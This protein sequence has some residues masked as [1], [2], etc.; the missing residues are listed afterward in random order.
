MKNLVLNIGLT[1]SLGFIQLS[2]NEV[3]LNFAHMGDLHGHLIP[4]D[5]VTPGDSHVKQGGL[6]YLYSAIEDIR[7]QDKETILI[8]TGDTVQGGAEVLYTR[9][10]AI[11]T[12]L[13]EF[14]IDYG[15]LGNW[16]HLYGEKR[17]AE[18]FFNKDKLAN[19]T[20]LVSNVYKRSTNE[21]L[22]APYKIFERKGVKI[23]IIGFTSERPAM[24]V[25]PSGFDEIRFTNGDEEYEKYV[26]LLRPQVDVLVVISE[27]GLAKNIQLAKKFPGVNV[28]FSSDM[29]EITTK[30]VALKN[31]TI[32]VEEGA[33]GTRLGHIQLFVKDGKVTG[34]TFKM[35]TIDVNIKPNA[36]IAALVE[37]VRAPFLNDKTAK[38]YKSQFSQKELRGN[39]I[40]TVGETEIDLHRSNFTDAPKMQA[41][42]ESSS[43]NFI[44]EAFRIESG[45][46]LGVVRGFRYGTHVAKGDIQR[47]DIFHYIPISPWI[48]I[49]EISAK[50]LL[51]YL[52]NVAYGSLAT[53][54]SLWKGGWNHTVSG[55]KY[56]LDPN[57]KKGHMVSNLRILQDGKYVAVDLNKTYTIAGYTYDEEPNKVNKIPLKNVKI[58]LDKDGNKLEAY[59]VIE[60]YLSKHNANPELNRITLIT[61][62]QKPTHGN[63]EIQPLH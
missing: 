59:E 32:I 3:T 33:D 28:I 25:G 5:H 19:W 61:P 46:D 29:H 15:A 7:K 50:E 45:A 11:I 40:K 58:M 56:N 20:S 4:R 2:A 10:Q 43:H 63:R 24:A 53:D 62:L 35:R 9:G 26:K 41:V 39:I 13:N 6:A 21:N 38:T 27:L 37:K 36:K 60:N 30:E 54:P 51:N 42:I 17:T 47:E 18:I 22:S 12:V 44:A 52:E 23:G 14:N 34:H 16:D 1:I 48:G 49:G 8:N 31:G 55:T 57:A